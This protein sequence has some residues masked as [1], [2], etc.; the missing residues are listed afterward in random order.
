MVKLS[1]VMGVHNGAKY[2]SE[3]VDSILAQTFSEFEFIIID[4]G[5]TDATPEI[6]YEYSRKDSRLVC[7]TLEK[8]AGLPHGLN[9]GIQKA[10]GNIIARMDCD[11][12]SLPTRFEQQLKVFETTGA[13]LVGTSTMTIDPNGIKRKA[14][15]FL[16]SNDA[17]GFR[18]PYENCIS[19]PSVMIRKPVLEAVGGYN[20]E[21]LNSQDYDLWLRLMPHIQMRNLDVP[22]IKYRQHSGR[23][24]DPS[25]KGV[26]THYSVCA[27]L[28]HFRTK[29]DMEY[30]SPKNEISAVVEGFYEVFQVGLSARERRCLNRHV[31]RYGR[32]CVSEKDQLNAL[33]SFLFGSASIREK[34]KWYLYQMTG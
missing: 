21:F 19:H 9:L 16:E 20:E 24:S 13:D 28:N 15:S 32:N 30:I 7:V 8:N 2:L 10:N 22:L 27:A 1:V 4:D 3:A 14:K 31:I 34:C 29:F 5:S 25:N 18:L 17:I 11:D 23:I 6:L 26:Q 12:V 33:K